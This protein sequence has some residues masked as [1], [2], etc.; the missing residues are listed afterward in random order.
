MVSSSARRGLDWILEKK[1]LWK[2]W[3]SIGKDCPGKWQNHHSWKFKTHTDVILRD[4]LQR[5]TWQYWFNSWTQWS[6]RSFSTLMISR[7]WLASL[8]HT[9]KKKK[10]IYTH[11]YIYI[12]KI[13]WAIVASVWK[14][15]T[16]PAN[17]ECGQGHLKVPRMGN[18]SGKE[19]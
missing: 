1:S 18:S 14:M 8:T 7:I 12:N 15:P 16:C 6:Q 10:G 2:G 5:W 4:T 13:T 9:K 11:I 19:T 17:G 3:S